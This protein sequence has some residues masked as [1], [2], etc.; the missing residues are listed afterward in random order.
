MER[1]KKAKVEYVESSSSNRMFGQMSS[2]SQYELENLDCNP[3]FSKISEIDVNQWMLNCSSTG[4]NVNQLTYTDSIDCQTD[5][6]AD[7][8]EHRKNYS[9]KDKE[10]RGF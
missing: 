1:K 2:H 7:M 6:E 8:D 5:Y 3:R 10:D 9:T 4:D